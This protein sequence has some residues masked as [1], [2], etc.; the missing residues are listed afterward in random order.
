M[1]F[2]HAEEA[3]TDFLLAASTIYTKLEQG[4]KTSGQS[5]AWFGRK[6]KQRRDDP[7]L[8]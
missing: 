7:V 4:A 5:A 2:A 6:K 8:R 3:W 1:D